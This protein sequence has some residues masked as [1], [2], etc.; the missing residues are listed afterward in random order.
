VTEIFLRPFDQ[1]VLG[2]TLLRFELSTAQQHKTLTEM[3]LHSPLLIVDCLR[4]HFV[5]PL[6]DPHILLGRAP[7]C[8]LI[9][10]S[11]IV[12][13]RHAELEQLAD[14][15]YRITNL[16]SANPLFWQRQPVQQRRLLTGDTLTID[17]QIPAL[18]VL[19]RYSLS[20]L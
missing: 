16:G 5:A 14:G 2:A 9:I 10:P 13:R 4:C 3:A 8:G 11:P 19:L 1:V 17:A 18:T 7:E 15:G 6:R 20:A 12:S